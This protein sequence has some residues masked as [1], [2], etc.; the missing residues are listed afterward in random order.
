MQI[1]TLAQS[2]LQKFDDMVEKTVV[3]R[4][5]RRKSIFYHIIKKPRTTS[6]ADFQPWNKTEENRSEVQPTADLKNHDKVSE[7]Q[8]I[9]GSLG[10]NHSF[11]VHIVS[12]QLTV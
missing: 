4:W 5:I 10:D 11:I 3:D 12:L 9:Y 1:I 8:P 7:A 6:H 2:L